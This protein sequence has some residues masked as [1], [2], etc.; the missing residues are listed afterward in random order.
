MERRRV[1][2]S[3]C[4]SYD[5]QATKRGPHIDYQAPSAGK[6]LPFNQIYVAG[7]R[8]KSFAGAGIERLVSRLRNLSTE[9]TSGSK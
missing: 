4:P 2:G 5:R 8:S 3:F 1:E 6:L 9:A 7:E